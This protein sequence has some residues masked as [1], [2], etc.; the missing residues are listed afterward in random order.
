MKKFKAHIDLYTILFVVYV[1]AQITN[2]PWIA[3][4]CVEVMF[5]VNNSCADNPGKAM[6]NRM[7]LAKIRAADSQGD[8][9]DQTS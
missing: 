7:V 4:Y 1:S 6:K 2:C 3:D 8:S 9:N 5:V